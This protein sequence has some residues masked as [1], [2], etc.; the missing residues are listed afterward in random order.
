MFIPRGEI[1]IRCEGPLYSRETCPDFSKALQVG[2]DI[3]M[4]SSGGL[5]DLVNHSCDP[6]L[7][8][9]E[10]TDNY[11]LVAIR[12]IDVGEELE[13]DY[14]T[15]MIDEPWVLEGCLCRSSK[16]RGTISN[17]PQLPLETKQYY[18]RLG[19]LPQHV[20]TAEQHLCV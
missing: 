19:V 3:W 1:V 12:D 16:C 10:I 11:Y 8:L 15:S 14:S 18:A 5:D 17:F 13:W 9:L 7:G 20:Y 6:N 4:G 2:T